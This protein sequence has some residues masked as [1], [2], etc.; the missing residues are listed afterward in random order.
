MIDRIA[1]THIGSVREET[2]EYKKYLRPGNA[3]KRW[4][5]LGGILQ[6]P[7]P[8]DPFPEVKKQ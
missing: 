5:S 2:D 4:L 3:V 1:S 8:E 7:K 6:M